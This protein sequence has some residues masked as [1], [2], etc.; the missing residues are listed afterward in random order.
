VRAI[1]EVFGRGQL[2]GR[3]EDE[4]VAR[5]EGRR[6]REAGLSVLREQDIR[7]QE[8]FNSPAEL[9]RFLQAVPIFEDYD[10]ENDREPFERYVKAASDERGVLMDRHWFVLHA[11]RGDR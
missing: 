6:L 3:W 10:P 7:Y 11:R 2:Y 4:P 1:K 9:D 8:Y 5:Q